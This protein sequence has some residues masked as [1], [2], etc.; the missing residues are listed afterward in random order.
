MLKVNLH[1]ILCM[2]HVI[3]SAVYKYHKIGVGNQIRKQ[4]S[5]SIPT[6]E[7]VNSV[8]CI[9]FC[10]TTTLGCRKLENDIETLNGDEIID[11]FLIYLNL[12]IKFTTHLT[13]G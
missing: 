6:I 9:F 12:F 13:T 3:L 10:A 8:L 5:E 11:L 2:Y 4:K 1:V 7:S